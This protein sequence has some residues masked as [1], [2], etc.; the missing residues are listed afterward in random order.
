MSPSQQKTGEKDWRLGHLRNHQN[1]PEKCQVKTLIHMKNMELTTHMKYTDQ[2]IYTKN[3]QSDIETTKTSD[4]SFF[5]SEAGYIDEKTLI[6]QCIVSSN[7]S[8]TVKF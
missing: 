4:P 7:T 5:L 1:Y 6:F 3:I 2:T 8:C